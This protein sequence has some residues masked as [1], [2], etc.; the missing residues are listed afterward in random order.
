[1]HNVQLRKIVKGMIPGATGSVVLGKKL[2]DEVRASFCVKGN[3]VK[4][5]TSDFTKRIRNT[6][7]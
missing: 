4:E 2:R 1:M 5:V 6:H 7:L 3:K